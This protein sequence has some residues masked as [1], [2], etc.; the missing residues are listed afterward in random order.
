MEIFVQN[1]F[2]MEG[3]AELLW[4]ESAA[5]GQVNFQ[6]KGHSVVLSTSVEELRKLL[7]AVESSRQLLSLAA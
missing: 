6:L 2:L 5:G 7:E 4:V 3:P 1:E